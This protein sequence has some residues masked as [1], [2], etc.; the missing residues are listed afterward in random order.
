V[1]SRLGD[2]PVAAAAIGA[3]CIAFS[4]ILVR[5]A[6]VSP[7]TAALF[8]CAY[9][10]PALA[11]LAWW[12]DRR[13]GPRDGRQRTLALVAGVF[14]AA[15]LVAWHHTIAAVGAGLATVLGNTQVVVVG[16]LAWVILA[17][18]P[19]R[20][21]LLATPL[22]L[23]GIVFISGVI[24]GDAYGANPPLGV[25]LGIVTAVAYAGFLLVL[26]QGNRDIRR[27][28]GPLFDATLTAAL[29]SAAAGF[30]MGD[31]DV[32]PAWPA[33]G[34]LVLLALSSQVAGWLLIS[35]SLPRLPAAVTSVVLTLQPVGSV[36]FAML[37]LAE[38]PSLVQLAGVVL[39]LSGLAVTALGGRR[40]AAGA[41]APVG[42]EP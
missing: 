29:A 25:A 36:L 39:V 15:D 18:R 21:V 2:R 14:F 32:A 24:G 42:A 11:L 41:T 6:D 19:E 27:P 30:V 37:L 16:L 34:W 38:E 13:Y 4:G 3:L 31:L 22:V 1:L 12:E 7:T 20:R 33:H 23:I 10:L 8:R 40:L 35:V 9:A 26:R 5:L 28:A 17:E